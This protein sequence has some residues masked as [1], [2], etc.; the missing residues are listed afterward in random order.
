MYITGQSVD[1]VWAYT[2]GIIGPATF[3][4][5]S[6]VEWPSGT[7]PD[8]PAVGETDI[9]SFYTTDGGTTYY[10]FKAGDAMA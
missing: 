9:L 8:A 7:A 6:S 1:A 10:G 2:T 3:T 5:P 4:Y